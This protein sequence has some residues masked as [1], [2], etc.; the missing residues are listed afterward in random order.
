MTGSR[1]GVGL[2]TALSVGV[3]VCAAGQAAAAELP[4]G[5]EYRHGPDP[6]LIDR[7]PEISLRALS[8]PSSWCGLKQAQDDAVN[9][10][11]NGSHKIHG[12]Y[13][14]PS[15][16]SDRFELLAGNFQT[17]A[18]QASALLERLYGRAIR[19]DMGTSCGP[20]YMD[21][22]AVRLASSSAEL[23]AAA[24][25][26]PFPKVF[27]RVQADLRSAGFAIPVSSSERP[28]LTKN[29]VVWLDG[30]GPSGVCG[31]ANYSDD[32]TRRPENWNNYGG[33]IALIYSPEGRF[34]GSNTVRH[35][36]GHNLGA[37]Q[38]DAPHAF[39][40][41]HCNDALEDTMCYPNSPRRASGEANALFFDYG[42]N[43]YW[44]PPGGALPG[45][46]VNLSNFICP[47]VDCNVPGGSASD[48]ASGDGDPVPPAVD[49]C[50]NTRGTDCS[51][52]ADAARSGA[53]VA[54]ARVKRRKV[55]RQ[56]WR[57]RVRV[58]GH[59]RAR[60]RVLCRGKTVRRRVVRV[61]AKLHFRVR[62]AKR[63]KVKTR[64]FRGKERR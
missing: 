22:S 47:T 45:W 42:H 24:F 34:C 46:A 62:C 3:L 38:P 57:V 21:I 19:F 32:P 49:S 9:E 61:P 23:R 7:L 13:A 39:D 50:P 26:T 40:G 30:P 18:L 41:S 6:V 28:S 15:D 8:V 10:V 59:G 55:A 53:S 33:R 43:D 36:I 29:Y 58:R 27:D 31:E 44:D 20:G 16:G 2:A 54:R 14:V 11:S 37:L 5:L 60:V 51:A 56:R 48:P 52:S 17:D 12:I 1:A 64:A 4:L 35:E 63:V 25:A